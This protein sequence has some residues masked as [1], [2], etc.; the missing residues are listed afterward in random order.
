MIKSLKEVNPIGGKEFIK[1]IIQHYNITY[2]SYKEIYVNLNKE[3][4]SIYNILGKS[5]KAE[6]LQ[7]ILNVYL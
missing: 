3:L 5:K 4:I 1:S 7:N 6:K 2:F